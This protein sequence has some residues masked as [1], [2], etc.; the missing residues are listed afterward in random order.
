MPTLARLTPRKVPQQRTNTE[1]FETLGELVRSVATLLRPPERLTVAEAAERY[2][3]I[4]NPG[5][6]IGPYR[7]AT[8]PYMAEPMNTLRSREHSAVVFVGPAQSSKTESL[9]LCWTAYSVVVDPMDAIIYCPT[10]AAARDF[11]VRRVDRLHRHSRDVGRMLLPRRDADNKTDKQYRSGMILTLSYPSVSEFA[12]RPIGRVALTDYDRMPDDVDGEGSPFD[13]ASKRTTTFGSFA[14]TLAESSPSRPI[15]NPKW[16]RKSPHEAP[17]CEGILGLY[18][19]GDRRRW[20]WPCQRCGEFFEGQ[21]E[22]LKWDADRAD[23][24]EAADT[25][26]LECPICGGRNA[27][28]ERAAMNAGGLWLAEG[29]AVDRHGRI[30]GRARRGT[31]A[32]FWMNGTAAAF[33]TWPKLVQAYMLAAQDYERT[34]SEDALRKFF[35]TDIGVPFVPRAQES[36]RLPEVLKARAEPLPERE[37]PADVRMLLASVD[38]QKNAFVVQ[39]HGISPGAPFDITVVDRFTI[40]KSTREDEEGDKQWVKPGSYLED[41]DRITEQV[42]E[43]TYPL[44]DGSGRKMMV[45]MTVCDSGGK[46]G[47]TANAYNYYRKLKAQGLAGRFHLVK[48]T[49]NPAAPRVRVDYPDS[50]RKDR[51]AGA[52]GDIPVMFLHSNLLKDELA[53]RLETLAP[54]KGQIRFPDWLEDWFYNELCA[55]RK[56]PKGWVNPSNARNEAWDLL[57]YLLGICASPLLRLDKQ[58]WDNPPGWLAE[59]DRNLMVLQPSQEKAFAPQPGGGYD[60]GALGSALA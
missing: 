14:M 58:D 60:F 20:Y 22:H 34:G 23:P 51:M 59:W 19:R 8:A 3:T 37:V 50:G 36:E 32:S 9:I 24:A 13:L 47:V 17:P 7:V 2:V 29:Q 49:T 55:E 25:V 35:N 5:S 18:N 4:N 56:E 15:T 16:M 44:S 31:V 48:G 6:Y 1:G 21:F 54:G 27:P 57:Y 26:Y 42:M 30:R 11:S 33:T 28:A 39:V 10:M 53:A 12:G 45:R 46:A 43:R 38:V 52:R 40:F 41:W